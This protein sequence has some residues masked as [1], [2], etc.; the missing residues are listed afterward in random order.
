MSAAAILGQ[1]QPPATRQHTSS[2]ASAIGGEVVV[3]CGASVS[4]VSEWS[5]VLKST[6]SEDMDTPPYDG[7]IYGQIP[8]LDFAKF[9]FQYRMNK[10]L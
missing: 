9:T 3:E 7:P 6:I 8:D 10:G 5:G 2:P 1:L 4:F